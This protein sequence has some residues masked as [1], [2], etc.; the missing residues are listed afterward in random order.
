MKIYTR[1]GDRGE[2]GL[3]DGSRKGKDDPVFEALGT[4]D[5][6]NANIGC[7][8]SLGESDRLEPALSRIQDLLLAAGSQIAC[9]DGEF[10]G[11]PIEDRHILEAEKIIDELTAE[12]PPLK[13]FIHPAG[14][15]LGAQLHVSRAVCRRLERVLVR[16]HSVSPLP[17]EL[18]SFI[19]RLSDLLFTLAR[20]ATHSAGKEET[21]WTPD[22]V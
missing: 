22:R 2:T 21:I 6:L 18:L 15:R 8:R 9:P 17:S 4:M 11:R 14:S 16:V 7:C 10:K 3:A 5:E 1:T 13:N 19:N 20:Y 12:I